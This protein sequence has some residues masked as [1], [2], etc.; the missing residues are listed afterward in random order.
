M[1]GFQERERWLRSG[2]EKVPGGFPAVRAKALSGLGWVLLFQQD[3]GRAIAALEEAVALYK[4]LGDDSGTAFALANLGYAVLHGGFRERVPAFVKEGEALAQGDLEGHMPAFL[5]MMLAAAAMAQ[6][7]PDSAVSQLEEGLALSRELGDPRGALMAL[8]IMGMAEFERGGAERGAA[9]L[10]EGARIARELGDRLANVYYV[11]GL[12][13]VTRRARE[14]AARR[15]ALGRRRSRP[16]AHG[17][18]P[19]PLRPRPLRLR[20]G[21]GRRDLLARR[22]GLRRRLGR[23]ADDEPGS[24]PPIR[25]LDGRTTSHPDQRTPENPRRCRAPRIVCTNQA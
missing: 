5:R 21:P 17:L 10:E 2:L 8:L 22:C 3:Y 6:G 13:K 4:S 11:W 15:E 1:E 23:G 18:V 7:D 14:A 16:R 12:G 19:L 24:S 25:P 9:L 20:T